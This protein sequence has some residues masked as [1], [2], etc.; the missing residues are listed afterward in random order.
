MQLTWIGWIE[1]RSSPTTRHLLS[2]I[3]RFERLTSNKFT[4]NV[5]RCLHGEFARK[6]QEAGRGWSDYRFKS[7]L[8]RER[9][10]CWTNDDTLGTK[11]RTRENLLLF[12]S[13][14]F[15]DFVDR[16]SV[17][18]PPFPRFSRVCG[19]SR[20]ASTRR[21]STSKD[22]MNYPKGNDVIEVDPETLFMDGSTSRRIC[23]FFFLFYSVHVFFLLLLS[24]FY[25]LFS[26]M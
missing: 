26:A 19:V 15:A 25:S 18:D 2:V 13:T 1:K 20:P 11:T 21:G 6:C 5:Q 22:T 24:R 14:V 9:A 17:I 10:H 12:S 4:A 23:F 8:T 16:Y 7:A 3:V